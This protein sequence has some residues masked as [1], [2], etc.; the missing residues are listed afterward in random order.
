MSNHEQ[1][2][3]DALRQIAREFHPSGW[4]EANAEKV[5]GVSP[6]EALEMAYDNIQ[7]CAASAIRSRRRP[8]K[9]RA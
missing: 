2:Y 8:K 5:Y 6:H 7:L 3:F 9:G 4:F 1:E